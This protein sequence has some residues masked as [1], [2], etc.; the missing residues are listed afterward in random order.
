MARVRRSLLFVPGAEQR[1][2]DKT[3]GLKADTFIYDLEDSVAPQAVEQARRL[4][5]AFVKAFGAGE[6]ERCVRVHA[7]TTPHFYGDLCQV[8][9]AR[10]DSIMLPKVDTPEEITFA[11]G[12]LAA[13]EREAGIAPGAIR[14]LPIIESALGL[15]HAY[16]IAKASAR[17]DALVLGHADFSRTLGIQERWAGGGGIV[18][19]ARCQVVIEAKAAGVDAIDTVYLQLD[20]LEGFRQDVI[21]GLR[22]GYD[23]KLLVHASQIEP[24]NALYTP[25][26][27]EVAYAKRVLEA[28]EAV[29]AEG[30]A[31]FTIDGRMIDI[32]VV[33]VERK[34]LERARRAGLL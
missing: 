6:Q 1:K 12:L 18:L 34:V 11:D 3:R 19:H 15:H 2:L 31:V 4:T 23:G 32:P 13:L 25:T 8:V 29:I 17:I 33:D 30:R 9:P 10:P 16:A 24:A 22:M 26:A 27:E 21:Q 20:D 14:L 28:Y 5:S 7:T